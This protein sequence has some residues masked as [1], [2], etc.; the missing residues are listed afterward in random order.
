MS[1]DGR[2]KVNDCCCDCEG[3]CTAVKIEKLLPCPFCGGHKL[4]LLDCT[5]D[6]PCYEIVCQDCG[7][8]VFGEDGFLTVAETWNTRAQIKVPGQPPTP[9]MGAVP[10][11]A[12]RK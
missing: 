2:C 4:K 1:E 6:D 12:P 5:M 8:A 9:G 10:Y 11:P 7:G 3:H